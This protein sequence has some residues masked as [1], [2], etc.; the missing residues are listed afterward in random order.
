MAKY[1]VDMGELGVATVKAEGYEVVDRFVTF[2]KNG[3]ETSV[4]SVASDHLVSIRRVK[5]NAKS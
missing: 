3:G 4:F 5:Q 1:V 2:Y